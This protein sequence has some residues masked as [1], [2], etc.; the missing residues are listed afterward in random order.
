MFSVKNS[1][2]NFFKKLLFAAT[3]KIISSKKCKV[4]RNNAFK[5][6]N[7][8]KFLQLCKPLLEDSFIALTEGISEDGRV[9][10]ATQVTQ[11]RPETDKVSSKLFSINESNPVPGKLCY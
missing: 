9:G 5:I 7:I 2:I 11:P 1:L 4:I 6:L 8:S 10:Q 3:P